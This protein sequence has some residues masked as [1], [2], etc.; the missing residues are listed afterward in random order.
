MLFPAQPKAILS[1]CVGICT[2]DADGL[3]AGCHRTAGEIARWMY[4]SDAE[5]V[6]LMDEVLPRRAQ[7]VAGK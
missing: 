4:Y 2:L 6:Q 7:Q 1:P 5:R 3:C